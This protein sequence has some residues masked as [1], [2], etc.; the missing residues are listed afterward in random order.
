MA[1]AV[2][3]EHFLRH[4]SKDHISWYILKNRSI[5][6][7]ISSSD[8]TTSRRTNQKYNGYQRAFLNLEEE[9]KHSNLRNLKL[10]LLQKKHC[11]IFHWWNTGRIFVYIRLVGKF[12]FRD[13]MIFLFSFNWMKNFFFGITKFFLNNYNCR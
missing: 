11:W 7:K 8:F 5:T 13:A 9:K 2:F 1:V 10:L 3:N 4:Y 12:G 6:T